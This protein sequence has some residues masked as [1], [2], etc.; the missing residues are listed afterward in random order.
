MKTKYNINEN[1]LIISLDFFYDIYN[2]QNKISSIRK[3]INKIILD[4]NIKFNGNKIVIYK[5]GMLIGTFYLTSYYLNKLKIN[6]K[7]KILTI[8]NSYFYENKYIE[9][10]NKNIKT[11]K[12]LEIY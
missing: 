1:E 2:N 9:I 7:E 10:N 12:I 4:N 6:N 8:N 11:K 3:Y 5:D